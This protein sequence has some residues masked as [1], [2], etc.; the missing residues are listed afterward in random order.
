MPVHH[1][2]RL[3]T[4]PMRTRA[5]SCQWSDAGSPSFQCLPSTRDVLLDPGRVTA[6]RI[7]A[8]LMLHSTI[9]TVSAPAT[10]LFRGSITHPTPL[11]CTLR[12][13]RYRR[14]TQHLLPGGS[15][16][17]TRAGLSPAGLHQLWLAPSEI[18]ASPAWRSTWLSAPLPGLPTASLDRHCYT[19]VLSSPPPAAMS[20]AVS[21]LREP[22]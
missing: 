1:R 9:S 18:R 4:F 22:L 21:T 11:L 17:L 8:L 20:F 16:G 15:L 10:C 3:L 5:Y 19:P 12:G 2:L 6:P 14:L 13:R 7:A